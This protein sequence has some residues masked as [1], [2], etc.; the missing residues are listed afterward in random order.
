MDQEAVENCRNL[1]RLKKHP[2][3]YQENTKPFTFS[4][5]VLLFIFT[6]QAKKQNGL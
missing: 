2:F 3:C 6:M 4:V 1:N 5:S